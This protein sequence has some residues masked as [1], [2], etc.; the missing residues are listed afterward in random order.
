MC[1]SDAYYES[2]DGLYRKASFVVGGIVRLLDCGEG[3]L[4]CLTGGG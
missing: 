2:V 4:M 3:F 1:F